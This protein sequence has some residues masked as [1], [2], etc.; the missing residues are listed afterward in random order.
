MTEVS[1]D[2][3][4]S[5][6]S[7]VPSPPKE[8]YY[9]DTIHAE[10]ETSQGIEYLVGWEDYPI[11]RSSWETAAQ[12][13][14]EQTLL[15]W[16]DKKREIAAGRLEEF[17]LTDFNR[18]LHEAEQACQ[19]RKHKR[20]LKRERLAKGQLEPSNTRFSSTSNGPR[21][22]DSNVTL[23]P[24]T[25]TANVYPSRATNQSQVGPSRSQSIRGGLTRPPLVG[26]GT[27]RGG[28]IRS[29]PRRSYD[30]DPSAPHKMFK[31]LSTKHRY[32]KARGYEPA[33]N[34]N[35]LELMRPSEWSSTTA[36]YSSNPGFQQNANFK[37]QEPG[38]SPRRT[39]SDVPSTDTFI[40]QPQ[41]SRSDDSK[42]SNH[43]SPVS[44]RPRRLSDRSQDL[45]LIPR[46]RPGPE[47]K[48]I[49]KERGSYFVN[50]GELL[51]TL[52]YGPDK[53]EI[54]E[55]RMCG[56]DKIRRSRFLRTKRNHVLEI[57]FQQLC[58][59]PDYNLLCRNTV[60]EKYWN[61]WVEGFEDSEPEIYHFGKE[62]SRRNLVAICIPEIQGHDVLLAYPP[63][64]EDFGFL[65]GD[66]RGPRDIFLHTAVR[67]A[68]GPIERLAFGSLQG[69]RGHL[70]EKATGTVNYSQ[71][72]TAFADKQAPEAQREL[73]FVNQESGPSIIEAPTARIGLESRPH[74]NT[75]TSPMNRRTSSHSIQ[76][77]QRRSSGIDHMDMDQDSKDPT[78]AVNSDQR[79]PQLGMRLPFDL[80]YE[81]EK[82]F[83]VTFQTLAT[84]A[85]KRLA[86]SFYV[87]F[88]QG[89]GGIEE[90]CQAVVEFLK[91]HHSEKNKA[92]VYS[93]RTPEDWEKFTQAKNGVVL[94]HES[95]LDFYKL[96]GLNNLCHQSTFNFWSFI[97]NKELGD[98]RPYFQRMFQ[99][100][101]VI[102]I[103]A[104]YMLSDPR[105]TVVVLSWF[106]DY[107]KSRYPGTWKLMLRPDV[108]NWLQKQIEVTGNSSYL[109]LAMYHLIMQITFIGDTK[110]RDILT[111]A[112]AGYTPNTVISPTKLPGYGFRTD[113]E[114]PN[115]PKDRTLTQEQRN[116]DHL[117]EFY[118]G[119]ALI[120]CYQFRK[121][122][123]LTASTLPRWD[124]WHH[125][126]IRV[127]STAFMKY[128]EI[129]YRWYWEKLKH[130]AAR[131]N[132][133]S[134][135]S[136]QT[137]FT[138]QT[139]RALSSE[140]AISRATPSY[141]PPLSHH[142]P[143][144]YQ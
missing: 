138:P 18:R 122:Y 110:S 96:Q 53:K 125:L 4:V 89:S 116:A 131:S 100:G 16:E 28:R 84:V 142:Y 31:L 106:E 22:T 77:L 72:N 107:A 80:D 35:Q 144:P 112:E 26:F 40:S 55:V 114:I 14:D 111:G 92:I 17:D 58:N 27:G 129:N 59:L 91:A 6:T 32:E 83:G 68:L 130:S 93:S 33:P 82:R 62:L 43:S 47:A 128:F 15:D 137:P 113:D 135:R 13:D 12:F 38:E 44:D 42:T 65:D 79:Q 64:S 36:A 75:A 103:T 95:S 119:W 71:N 41:I 101:G 97:L 109:W 66:F 121:F 49:K 85:E 87:L 88:P 81:F 134:E 37:G 117:V 1:D 10:R 2:D 136:S 127:G 19:K 120:N 108:L 11:E 69:Q 39:I 20:H 115:I 104:D 24:G 50:P 78:A 74:T 45:Y 51:C 21:F 63:N 34:V 143:Q 126:Q 23:N 9:V 29:R 123:V 61:G 90:E 54:G 118:A 132:Y 5:L 67:S 133:H 56:L 141:I 57:W 86:G 46:R 73:L 48:W 52:Y 25:G 70:T 7:T 8:N 140:S 102:L 105:G 3:D 98:N 139:P 60:N 30:A 76:T 99:T 94:I 124:E